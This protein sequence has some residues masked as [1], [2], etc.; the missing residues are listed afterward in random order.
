MASSLEKI[1]RHGVRKDFKQN[2]VICM[3]GEP[4]A[5]MYIVLKGKFNVYISSFTDFP[6]MVSEIG[7]GQFFG[8]MS[9]LDGEPRS[10]TVIAAEDSIAMELAK[11]DFGKLVGD[12]SEIA[13][14]VMATFSKRIK[15]LK[16]SLSGADGINF[17]TDRLEQEDFVRILQE[18]PE[19]VLPL[20]TALSA[21]VRELNEQLS[22]VR[23]ESDTEFAPEDYDEQEQSGTLAIMPEDHRKYGV[24]APNKYGFFVEEANVSCP[25]C[26]HRFKANMP[27]LAKLAQKSCRTGYDQRVV[28]ENFDPLWYGIWVCPECNY[29]NYYGAFSKL[30]SKATSAL[31]NSGYKRRVEKFS[32]YKTPLSVDSVFESYY[33]ALLCNEMG[34]RSMRAC[35]K[36]W[37]RLYWLY[38]DRNDIVNRKRAATNALAE[39]ESIALDSAGDERN[40]INTI[41]AELAISLADYRKAALYYDRVAMNT[42]RSAPM[43]YSQAS[44]RLSEL[45][46]KI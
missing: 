42:K 30:S 24:L 20:I 1:A 11:D 19:K 44:M 13:L 40:Q 38:S 28:Y 3:M 2:D 8:E 14:S 23:G 46:L 6:I 39:Y 37:L 16:E 29:A 27:L 43:L 45:K 41:I 26:S 17:S 5:H 9:V 7:P 35:A 33:L 36:T 10:A 18:S 12:D 22:D 32:G 34:E 4:G 15:T 21:R 31:L 25:V